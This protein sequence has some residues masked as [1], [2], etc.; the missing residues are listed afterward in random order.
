QFS[1]AAGGEAIVVQRASRTDPQDI[2][3]WLLPVGEA[4]QP[5]AEGRNGG[6]FRVT[7]DGNAAAIARGEGIALISLTDVGN[8]P[9]FLPEFGRVL[10]FAPD[11]RAAAMV[12]F[13]TED[14]DR[15]FLQTLVQFA[16]DG[17]QQALLDTE[18][19]ILGCE[20]APVRPLLYCALTQVETLEA[21][22][23]AV[24]NAETDSSKN[25]AEELPDIAAITP[26]TYAERPYLAAIALDSGD[27]TSIPLPPGSRDVSF[28]LSP[29]GLALLFD[30]L[31]GEDDLSLRPETN[32][33]A[34]KL[35]LWLPSTGEPETIPL[36]GRQPQWLP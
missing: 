14:A 27:I 35:W 12:D 24:E 30:R 13:N 16:S 8:P 7:P 32:D 26:E 6:E 29:D 17:R 3:L 25:L 23:S 15:R 2:G 21:S 9:D 20:Y 4:P 33:E 28:S 1:L 22:G 34:T 36:Q 5:L 31:P 11:G 19:S 10:A 18:G